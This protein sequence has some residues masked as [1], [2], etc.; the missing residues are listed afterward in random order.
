MSAS[1]VLKWQ[2]QV[3]AER[4]WYLNLC[5][6]LRSHLH[7][8]HLLGADEWCKIGTRQHRSAWLLLE[9]HAE[10]LSYSSER[11]G[12]NLSLVALR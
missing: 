4:L 10:S 5:L 11:I 1:L 8:R 2:C 12:P 9:A 3:Q 6:S 7:C